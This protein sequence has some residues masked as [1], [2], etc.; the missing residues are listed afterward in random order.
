MRVKICDICQER[1]HITDRVYRIDEH[2]ILWFIDKKLDVCEN[3]WQK[4]R[5]N[6]SA[7]K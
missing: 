2:S 4:I 7:M 3:C 1:I 6:V 5:I